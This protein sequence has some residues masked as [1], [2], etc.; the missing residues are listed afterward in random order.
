[1]IGMAMKRFGELGVQIYIT[2]FDVN[3]DAV[4]GTQEEKWEYQ[5]QLYRDMLEACLESGVCQAFSIFGVS[6]AD[7]WYRG[8]LEDPEPLPFDDDYN[9]KPA[10][11]ALLELLTERCGVPMY[12]LYLPLVLK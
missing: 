10:Y 3:L 7:T 4:Q 12:K 2:E 11:W 1:M 5:A 6:D 8:F 9:P